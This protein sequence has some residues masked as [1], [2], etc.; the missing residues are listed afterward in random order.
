MPPKSFKVLEEFPPLSARPG[1][2]PITGVFD[3][4]KCGFWRN[5]QAN[6]FLFYSDILGV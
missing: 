4:K 5:L 3:P 2:A 1:I 6:V